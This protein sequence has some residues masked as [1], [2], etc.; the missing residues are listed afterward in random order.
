MRGLRPTGTIGGLGWR[1]R[2]DPSRVAHSADPLIWAILAF[3]GSMA[4]STAFAPSPV[5]SLIRGAWTPWI[6]AGCL[7]Y[8]LLAP[9]LVQWVRPAVTSLLLW[10]ALGSGWQLWT[11]SHLEAG[12]LWRVHGILPHPNDTALVA[13]LVPLVN[14]WLWPIAAGIILLSGSRTAL[15]GL[16]VALLLTLR[17]WRLRVLLI[18]A[19]GSSLLLVTHAAPWTS[20]VSRFDS[21]GVAWTM[22]RSAPWIGTGPHTFVDHS[23]RL[24]PQETAFIPW[25]HSLYLELLAEQGLLGLGVCLSLGVLAWRQAS[26]PLRAALTACA[27]MGVMDLT[28]LKPWVM[29]ATAG[30][31]TLA[32]TTQGD[33]SPC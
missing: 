18:V 12:R 25:A 2:P 24:R 22:W 8:T 27:V 4:L 11:G 13:L 23:W 17:S 15:V 16:A 6:L 28:L 21:W 10:I 26:P 19:A 3:L 5:V 32:L 1:A 29:G 20:I 31:L 30:L 9:R 7:G 14:P 33:R